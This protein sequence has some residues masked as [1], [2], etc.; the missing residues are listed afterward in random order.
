[1]R[2]VTNAYQVHYIL[3]IFVNISGLIVCTGVVLSVV[4]YPTLLFRA[5]TGWKMKKVKRD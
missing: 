5:V 4:L 1:M 3:V 2:T